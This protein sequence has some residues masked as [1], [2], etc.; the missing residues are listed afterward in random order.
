MANMINILTNRFAFCPVFDIAYETSIEIA[1]SNTDFV[2]SSFWA[3]TFA[4]F[5][6]SH[7]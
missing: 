2:V 6:L 3:A 5:A 7:D 1:D 4:D